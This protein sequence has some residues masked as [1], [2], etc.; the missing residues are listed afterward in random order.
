MKLAGPEHK[1]NPGDAIAAV[2]IGAYIVLVIIA[3]VV[4]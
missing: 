4:K 2:L 1:I 3:L